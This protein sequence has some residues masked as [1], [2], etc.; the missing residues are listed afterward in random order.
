MYEHS[1]YIKT[2]YLFPAALQF[3][4]ERKI[5]DL[6]IHFLFLDFFSHEKWKKYPTAEKTV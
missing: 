6:I 2:I 1:S 5:F 3:L 4:N